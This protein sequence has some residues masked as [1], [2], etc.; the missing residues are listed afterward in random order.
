MS[1]GPLHFDRFV[2]DPE[3]RTLSAGGA[4][5]AVNGRYLD[6][7][8]LMAREPGRLITKDRFLQEV[9]R[10]APVTD[11]ALTQCVRSLRR[12]LGDAA[13]RPRFIETVPGHGYRF[14]AAV[15]AGAADA[16]PAPAR[17]AGRDEGRREA[18]LTAGRAGM[19]GGGAAGLAGGALYG[20]MT[21]GAGGSLSALVVIAGL[22]MAVGLLGGA[23]V[24]FGIGAAAW[25]PSRPGLWGVAG[26]AL[27]GLLT[28]AVVKL[29]G[30]DAFTLLLGRA[31]GDITGAGEGLALGAAVGLGAWIGRG[32]W[33]ARVSAPAAGLVTGAAGVLIA[34]T[35]GRLM[36]GSLALLTEG[37]PGA[38]LDL[39]RLGPLFGEAGFGPVSQAV[40]AGLE[41][42]LFGACVAA[43]LILFR[44]RAGGA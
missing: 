19:I 34:L 42:A 31:P 12:A 1:G 4:R 5:V 11:E 32:P 39:D 9:W 10:G 20:V 16:A 26:G 41:G 37:F 28:G 17:A 44:R 6:A 8:I 3:G 38:R 25:A 40:T 35:G 30:L 7:L 27:G 13:G 15:T 22:T 24:G 21:G 33:P 43:A 2:L 23:G 29:I 14:I 18:V 36:G